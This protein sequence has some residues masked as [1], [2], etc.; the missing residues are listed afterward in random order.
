MLPEGR[1]DVQRDLDKLRKSIHVNV[2]RFNRVKCKVLHLGRD[3]PQ[4]EYRDCEPTCREGLG[5][6]GG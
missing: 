6:L 1:H 4:Y 2:M 5:G 3:N